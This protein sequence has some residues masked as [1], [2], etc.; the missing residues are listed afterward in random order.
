LGIEVK[1]SEN[2]L[3]LTQEKYALEILARA[4]M[5]NCKLASTPLYASEKLSAH[6]GN[7]LG[8]EDCTRYRSLVGALQYLSHTHP[9]LAFSINKVCQFLSAPTTMH[10]TAV[11]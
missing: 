8:P 1:P 7:P 4:S 5:L 2:G 3:V 11:K 10:Y 6:V 9:D